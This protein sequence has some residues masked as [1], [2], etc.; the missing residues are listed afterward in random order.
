MNVICV[1]K[2]VRMNYINR[3][4]LKQESIRVG[5]VPPVCADRTCFNSHQMSAPVDGGESSTEL[6]KFE[7][8]SGVDQMSLAGGEWLPRAYVGVGGGGSSTMRSNVSW[9]MVTWGPLP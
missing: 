4:F 8:V 2:I 9:V 5:C 1:N 3:L 6:N 7:Q